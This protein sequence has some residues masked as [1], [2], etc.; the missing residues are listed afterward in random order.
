MIKILSIIL[1]CLLVFNAY[2]QKVSTR[3]IPEYSKKVYNMEYTTKEKMKHVDFHPLNNMILNDLNKKINFIYSETLKSH[4]N[5]LDEKFSIQIDFTTKGE[6][7]SVSMII[8]DRQSNMIS[9]RQFELFSNKIKSSIR[10]ADYFNL[11][12][13]TIENRYSSVVLFVKQKNK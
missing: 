6:L 8:K 4:L 7:L 11:L 1:L 10:I 3:V 12:N 9:D 13:Y 2:T 5:D